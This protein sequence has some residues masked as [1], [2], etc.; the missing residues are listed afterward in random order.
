VCVLL[1]TGGALASYMLAKLDEKNPRESL[2]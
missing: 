2:F 1:F